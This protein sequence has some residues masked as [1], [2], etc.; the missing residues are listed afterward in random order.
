L[1]FRDQQA[2]SKIQVEIQKAKNSQGNI[3]A[4]PQK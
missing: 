1:F 2:G 3:E 4:T